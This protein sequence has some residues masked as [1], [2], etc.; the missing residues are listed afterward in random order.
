MI[1]HAYLIASAR[2]YFAK[3]LS[4][5]TIWLR[6]AVGEGVGK[7]VGK[8]EGGAVGKAVSLPAG[9]PCAGRDWGGGLAPIPARPTKST[10]SLLAG[11]KAVVEGVDKAVGEAVG[12]A[13]RT[14][15][16]ARG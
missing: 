2:A 12:E 5:L 1:S 15:L 13:V 10:E 9:S 6:W 3:S 8:A 16:G 11:Y 7:G 14:G 4:E